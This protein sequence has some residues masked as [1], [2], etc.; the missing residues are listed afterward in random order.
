MAFRHRL[1]FIDVTYHCAI[2]G[3]KAL[4]HYILAWFLVA[5][6]FYFLLPDKFSIKINNYGIQ[7]HSIIQVIYTQRVLC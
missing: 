4:T 5:W 1:T 7:K 3:N 2:L 6:M